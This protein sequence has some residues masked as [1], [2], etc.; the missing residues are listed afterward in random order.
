MR[1]VVILLSVAGIAAV[2]FTL[3]IAV[4][5]FVEHG[6]FADQQVSSLV[7]VNQ[8]AV[9]FRKQRGRWPNSAAELAPPACLPG[10]CR[11][12]AIPCDPWGHQLQ[13]EADGGTFTTWSL[14]RN[15]TADRGDLSR[16]VNDSDG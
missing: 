14:G 16:S 8:A 6:R 9:E 3:L 7:A 15:G 11:F 4:Q 5:A 2:A 10:P 12:A 13:V 1:L